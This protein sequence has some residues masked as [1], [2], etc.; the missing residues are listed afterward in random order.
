MKRTKVF[1]L[2]L[3]AL[4]LVISGVSQ[5]QNASPTGLAIDFTASHSRSAAYS[6]INSK[7]FTTS[8]N[9]ELLLAFLSVDASSSGSNQVTAVS[10]A[11]LTWQLV[12]R[13]NAQLGD[14]EIW[15]AFAPA[16]LTNATVTARLQSGA[17]AAITIVGFLGADPSGSNGSGAIGATGTFSAASGAP[18]GSVQTTRAGSWVLGVGMDWDNAIKR[19]PGP[20]QTLMQQYLSTTGST[21]WLQRQNS[22]IPAAGT[23]VVI[24]DTAPTTDRFDLALVEVLPGTGANNAIKDFSVSAAPSSQSIA[25]GGSTSY[26]TTITPINGY[27]GTVNLSVSGLP[28]GATATFNPATLSGSGNSQLNITT[29]GTVA[30]GTYPLTITATDGTLTHS[31]GVSLVVSAAADFTLTVS[32]PSITVEAGSTA[33]TNVT[34]TGENGYSAAANLAATGL[35]NGMTATFNPATVNGSGSSQLSI[36]TTSGVAPGQYPITI[37]ATSGNLSHSAQATLT[38]SSAGQGPQF[39]MDA[40]ASGDLSSASASASTGLFSTAQ[41]NE[42]LLA[43]ISADSPSSTPNQVTAV[44]GGGLTWELVTR[45]NAQPGDSEIWRAWASAPLANVSVTAQLQAPAAA[46]ITVVSFTGADATGTNGSGAIGSNATFSAASGVPSGSLQTTRAGSWV[47]G[48]G[49]DWSNAVARTPDS[50]QVLVHQYLATVNDT[51]WVQRQNTP[52]AAA[53]TTVSIDDTAPTGDEFNL[54][55]VEVLPAAA[56]STNPDFTLSATP[57]GQTIAV[58]G[59]TTFTATV[60]PEN[61]Y[62]ATVNFSVSGLPAGA[63]AAFTPAS[64]NGSGSSQLNVTSDGTIAPGSYPLTLTATDGAITHTANVTLTV[65]GA[66]DFSLAVS[67]ASQAAQPGA[68]AS[69]NVTISGQN[70]YSA[71]ADLSVSGLPA[72]ATGTFNP[73]S[74]SGSGS[75]QLMVAVG[76]SVAPGS[77]ALTITAT[78][79]SI[80]HTANATLVVSAPADFTLAAS[81]SSQSAQVGGSAAYTLTVTGQNGY[82]GTANLSVA[83]LPSG[84]TATFNPAAVAGSGTSQMT[85]ATTSTT[86]TGSYPLTVTAA[87]GSLSHTASVTLVVT[88]AADFTV[89]TSPASQSV[90]AGSATGY[91]VSITALNG[92]AAATSLSVSGLP[93]GATATFNPASVTGSGSSQLAVSTA[94][95]TPAGSYA[96]TITASGSGITHTSSA[97]L[98]VATAVQHSVDLSWTDSDSGIAGYNVYRAT[99]SPS[100]YVLVNS[101]LIATTTYTDT[102]VQSGTTYYYVVTAVNTAGQE[103]AYSSPVQAQIPSP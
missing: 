81:P 54:A 38:V 95:T 20:N 26:T 28:S 103:S 73:A 18:S 92:Y 7:A 57:A 66:P 58:G 37:T 55:V 16:P 67:P 97:T 48:V 72:G 49:N 50:N 56:T 19:T 31:A 80:T 27:S 84:A 47:F 13:S 61:G 6:A 89:S 69:Y 78:S 52:T 45:A 44:S 11:G 32:P 65:S 12:A 34:I 83:G 86:P 4:C 63:T 90:G 25:V 70:G 36:A 85:I 41:G 3:L 100:G 42:L 43:F 94:S 68:N 21:Y 33:T 8:G 2:G 9:N 23:N 88:A 17:G 101:S 71:S 82:A 15:R 77:Y 74:V 75:S 87:S 60:T 35:P 53:G 14:A 5:A 39:A 102:T 22:A 99:G 91:T 46:S 30:P 93:A 40:A 96:L 24:N 79:G 64:V 76:S 51:Y 62:S 59:S 98:V 1:T 10:G 29:D